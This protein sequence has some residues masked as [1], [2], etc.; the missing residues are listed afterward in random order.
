MMQNVKETMFTRVCNFCVEYSF[1]FEIVLITTLSISLSDHSLQ[2]NDIQNLQIAMTI[3]CST[4]IFVPSF[5]MYQRL[6]F[7]NKLK[8]DQS[9]SPSIPVN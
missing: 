8:P 6:T 7:T 5:I 9:I 1:L 2:I 4:F 3:L